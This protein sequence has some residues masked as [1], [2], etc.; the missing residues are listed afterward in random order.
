MT[1][2]IRFTP[3]IRDDSL[4]YSW[5]IR[6]RSHFGRQ[7]AR[8]GYVLALVAGAITVR[9]LLEPV[10]E[11]AGF[12]VFLTAVLIG[13]WVGGIG[14]SLIGQTLL[15]LAH[16]ILFA[17]VDR[18]SGQA[19]GRGI[20]G[21]VAY[22]LVGVVVALLSDARRAALRRLALQNE[23]IELQQQELRATVSSIGDAVIVADQ[24]GHVSLMNPAA[25]ALTGWQLG[26]A[27]GQLL[28]VVF[29][30]R[31]DAGQTERM[32]PVTQ[33]LQRG[34][35][36]RE[37]SIVMLA[38]RATTQ[39]PV[40][41]N[42][43][44]ICTPS[45]KVT[46]AVLVIRDES[47]RRRAEEQLLELNRRKDDFLATLAHELRN[48][49][50]P[51]RN[52]LDLLK[53][54]KGDPQVASEVQEIME[55]QVRHVIRLV[56]DLLDVS[57]ISRGKLQLRMSPTSLAQVAKS[58]VQ[59]LQPLIDQAQHR[60]VLCI[61]AEL[62]EIDA[63]P[64]RLTQIAC[65]LLHNA[66]KFTPSG[67]RIELRVEKDDEE[68]R[69]IVDDNGL[70]IHPDKLHSIFEMFNQGADEKERGKSGLGIG[71]NLARKLAEMHGGTLDAQSA[72]I[73]KG[74][75]FRLRLPVRICPPTPVRN[76]GET[77]VQND[78]QQ[79]SCRVLVVDDNED[80]LR[81]ITL[82]M[83]SV[84]HETC[85]A[86][87]GLEAVEVAE[88]FRPEVILM[89][90]GMPILNGYEA[91]KR[92]REKPWG[93]EI[94]IIALTGWGQ[95]MDRQRTRDAGFD[96]HLVK[97]VEFEALQSCLRKHYSRNA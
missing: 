81:T 59:T 46:G 53:L 15:L 2:P 18:S 89:D 79:A 27:R 87:N 67:G 32:S 65:N 60:L 1:A 10:M 61:P 5:A 75:T 93:K 29:Q 43:T 49:L 21:I 83:Q 8:Y 48:P 31:D 22:Y 84:G 28:E 97:P 7:L 20:V 26:D 6:I 11:G 82:M 90:L 94:R 62:G 80:A 50:A 24:T 12:S 92:L 76:P 88:K 35:G 34:T 74:S 14:P 44:P 30:I 51:I 42:A 19:G 54:S 3:T 55:R 72:G 86:R 39:V 71:L 38:T 85:T 36:I 78:V 45:G 52:G 47:D 68:T 66:V 57:R 95:E 13:A 37:A 41:Y 25:E 63:D 70:G 16:G 69:L 64:D 96:D 23:K 73:N 33:V 77:Q 40:T 4:K 58:A 17:A 56:D 91:A 9:W